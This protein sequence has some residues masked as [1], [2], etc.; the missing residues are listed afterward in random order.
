M[1]LAGIKTI[2][3]ANRFLKERFLPWHNER[4]TYKVESVYRGIPK[5]ADLDIVFSVR[6]QRKVNKDNTISFDGEIYQLMPSN[7]IRSFAGR[8]V[9][10]LVLMDG[11]RE[12]IY[13]GKRVSFIE[14]GEGRHQ[15]QEEEK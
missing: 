2:E 1:R 8:I 13:E 12:V 15:R 7:G 11:R 9:E 5:G 10:V 6:H 14:L 4:Y 3:E